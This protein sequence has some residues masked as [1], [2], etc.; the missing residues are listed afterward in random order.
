MN[1]FS[2][3]NCVVVLLVDHDVEH[4]HEYLLAIVIRILLVKQVWMPEIELL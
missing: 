4:G 3:E 1:L 2:L